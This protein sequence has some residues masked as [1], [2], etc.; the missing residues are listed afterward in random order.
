[1]SDGRQDEEKDERHE[2]RYEP[3]AI[4][5]TAEFETLAVS[6]GKVNE[7]GGEECIFSPQAS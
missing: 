5:E 3:P 4:L 7:A 2:R 1:M 6:C